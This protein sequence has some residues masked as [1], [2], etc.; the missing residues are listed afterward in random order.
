MYVF[1]RC[2]F[3]NETIFKKDLCLVKVKQAAGFG[4][5]TNRRKIQHTAFEIYSDYK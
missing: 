4:A 2:L 3:V 5:H 1:T